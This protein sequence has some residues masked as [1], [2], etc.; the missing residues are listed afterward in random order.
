MTKELNS[1]NEHLEEN[2]FE[3]SVTELVR[4]AIIV[5]CIYRSPDGK[6]ERFLNK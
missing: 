4:Y 3:L 5:I 1:V 2:T 6:I